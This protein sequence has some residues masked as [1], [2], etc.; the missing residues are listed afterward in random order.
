MITPAVNIHRWLLSSTLIEEINLDGNLIG[1][2]GARELLEALQGRKEGTCTCTEG[3]SQSC[4]Q[5]IA[6]KAGEWGTHR[7]VRVETL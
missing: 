1:D 4:P 5:A 2:G 7:L 3:N 6:I